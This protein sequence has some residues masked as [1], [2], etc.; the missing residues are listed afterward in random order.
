MAELQ[1]NLNR[2]AGTTGLDAQRAA[3]IWAGVSGKDLVGALNAK[4]GT[5][6]KDIQGALNSIAGTSGLGANAASDAC[7]TSKVNLIPANGASFETDASYWD[8]N[9]SLTKAVDTS[10]CA[11]GFQSLKVTMNV[12]GGDLGIKGFTPGSNIACTA[13]NTY[14]FVASFLKGS[15]SRQNYYIYG[16]WRNAGNTTI[17]TF[18]STKITAN[19]WS[20]ARVTAT[21][22]ALTTSVQL[23]F[24]VF[25]TGIS[26]DTWWVDKIG[27]WQDNP[28][29]Q[30]SL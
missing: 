14:T 5:T 30:W 3:N 20:E 25:D 11:A 16:E 9:A 2:L 7:L 24:I 23:W 4:A 18:Q 15:G 19:T 26:T 29:A 12:A 22:P 27:M 1:Y 13:G 6:G 10:T 17:S 8:I 21:A 28:T